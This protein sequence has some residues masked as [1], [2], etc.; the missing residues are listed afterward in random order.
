[1]RYVDLELGLKFNQLDDK[2]YELLVYEMCEYK[3]SYCTRQF[4]DFENILINKALP[5]KLG[6]IFKTFITSITV[7]IGNLISDPYQPAEKQALLMKEILFLIK[8]NKFKANIFTK[9]DL[10][11]RDIA[12]IN[13]IDARVIIPFVTLNRSLYKL[14]EPN[15]LTPKE[16]L[17]LVADL[18]D[19]GIKTGV[20]YTILPYINDKEIDDFFIKI[21]DA[22]AGFILDEPLILNTK[23]KDKFF[24]FLSNNKL[25]KYLRRYNKLYEKREYPTGKVIKEFNRKVFELSL[26]YNIPRKIV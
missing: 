7:N 25:S 6:R 16:R 5:E 26:K 9:S 10:I 14:L 17:K 11:K 18:N 2:L 22:G 3:C 12:L 4:N 21:K 20:H 23:D 24:N 13:D 15:T 1:M 19:K 8:A